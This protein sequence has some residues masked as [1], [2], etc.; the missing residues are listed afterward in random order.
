MK[1]Y[2]SFYVQGEEN[3][4]N[5]E[6]SNSENNLENNLVNNSQNPILILDSFLISSGFYKYAPLAQSCKLN[7]SKTLTNFIESLNLL[8]DQ[9]IK[10]D[11]HKFGELLSSQIFELYHNA[12]QTI[13]ECKE[14]PKEIQTL[15]EIVHYYFTQ[16][17]KGENIVSFFNSIS[18]NLEENLDEVKII[19]QDLEKE[20]RDNNYQ[21]CGQLLG[22]L[23]K[24]VFRL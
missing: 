2:E 19:V 20:F 12:R 18:K 7:L 5:I 14:T 1:S 3:V 9:Q 23:V 22:S 13:T 21:V 11:P 8:N 10:S 6:K 16:N 24:I 17:L 15:V 4:N